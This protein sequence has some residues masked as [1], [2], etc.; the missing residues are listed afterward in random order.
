MT[1]ANCY[2]SRRDQRGQYANIRDEQLLRDRPRR[3]LVPGLPQRQRREPEQV[4]EQT[5]EQKHVPDDRLAEDG[6]A[7]AM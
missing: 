6:E 2:R 7:E 5:A 1:R 4:Q 3:R